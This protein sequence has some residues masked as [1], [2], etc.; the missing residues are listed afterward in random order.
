M[1]P[2]DSDSEPALLTTMHV[3]RAVGGDDVSLSWLVER[4][5]PLL[6]AQAR[7]RLGPLGRAAYEP[8]DLVQDAWL[9]LLPKLSELAAQRGRLTPVLLSYLSSIIL[10]KVQNVLRREA[11]RRL[12]GASDSGE[13]SRTIVSPAS[14]VVSKV[15]RYERKDLV[16]DALEEL[17]DQDREVL[18][19]RGIEQQEL[20]DVAEYLGISRKAASKRYSRALVRLRERLPGSVFGEFDDPDP[21]E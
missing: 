14:G 12:H 1:S 4:L 13:D 17:P 3:Q 7:W 11:R 10:N 6:I 20:E 9:T 16:R 15:M 5:N 21:G 19:M 18:L 8:S 2:P